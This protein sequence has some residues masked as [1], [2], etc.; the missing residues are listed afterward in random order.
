MAT[1]K[2]TI[3]ATTAINSKK[4]AVSAPN[5]FTTAKLDAIQ[6]SITENMSSIREA[7]S[8]VNVGKIESSFGSSRPS[9]DLGT[10][11]STGGLVESIMKP[12]FDEG[13]VGGGN[14]SADPKDAPGTGWF[15]Y[16]QNQKDGMGVITIVSGAGATIAGIVGAAAGTV[17]SAAVAPII[18]GAAAGAGIGFVIVGATSAILDRKGTPVPDAITGTFSGVTVG[19][20]GVSFDPLTGMG[21]AK[22]QTLGQFTGDETG[23]SGVL[24]TQAEVR[25]VTESL[26]K[27]NGSYQKNPNP[28]SEPV[29]SVGAD[30]RDIRFMVGGG[31]AGPI[32][33]GGNW[34][35]GVSSA[36]QFQLVATDALLA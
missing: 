1:P 19:K 32:M 13:R 3:A 5:Q 6:A 33:G 25:S 16:S 31:T 9:Q 14:V 15:S 17:A 12:G 18:V 21:P 10:G 7:A 22:I 34:L 4:V 11:G 36:S 29:G 26:S 8:A 20:N 28:M 27:A 2:T 24:M 35:A 30:G 23:W